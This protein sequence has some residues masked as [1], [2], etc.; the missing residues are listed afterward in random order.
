MK[1]IGLKISLMTLLVA[2]MLPAMAQKSVFRTLTW[3]QAAE[4]A[5][6]EG[7]IVLVD[8]M[9]KPMNEQ[10]KQAMAKT[11]RD[12]FKV[13]EVADFVREKTIAIKIDMGSEAGKAFAPKLVMNMYP[14]YGFFMPNGDILGVVSPYVLAQEPRKLI[15]K[16][17]EVL[18]AAAV[19]RSNSRAIVFEELSLE[20]A[21]KKGEKEGKLVFIDAYTSWCQPCVMM[22]KNIFTLDRVADFYN[23]H[24]I[25]VK[26]DFGQEKA[27]AER[28]K[29]SGYPSFIFVNGKGKAVYVAGGYTEAE[30]FIGYGQTALEK[31]KGIVF[32]TGTWAQALEKA[33][34]EHKYIFMDC[35]TS[36][37]GPCKMLAKN[38]FTDPDAAEFFNTHFV[39]VKYDMEKGEGKMLK[40]KF[41]VK[42]FP[43]L[44]F[45]DGEGELVHCTVGAP[46]LAGLLAEGQAVLDGKGL[47]ALTKAYE[48]GNREPD[49]ITS[50]LEALGNAYKEA[51]AEKVCLDY[52]ATLDKAKLHEKAYWDLFVKYIKDV[53]SDV[54]AYVYENRE[55]LCQSIGEKEVKGKIRTVWMI[56]ANR[57][58]TGQGEEAVLDEKGFKRYCKRLMKADVAGKA[59]IIEDA[60]M[61][62]AEKLGDWKTYIDLG[63]AKLKAGKVG[64][65]ILYNWGLRVNRMCKDT[66]LRKR[67][68]A[69][70]EQAVEDCKKRETEGGKEGMMSFRPYFERLASDLQQPAVEK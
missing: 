69:W 4:L 31:A 39:N 29:V 62:N 25:N 9:R 21:V 43:T 1:K 35:Y 12:I 6:K 38:V 33:K 45:I 68:A 7:K 46:D 41:G 67:A 28:F 19:K 11:E 66:A 10:A 34:A 26:L 17:E 61:N 2:F 23:E 52:F 63:D 70:F 50:Y 56:G 36:W 16:G 53:D 40:E 22:A 49:F 5:E 24:F 8:A 44:N 65:L 18:K 58:V 51:E 54:F 30:E 59:E 57:F 37:C 42:A 48:A 20:E 13:K 3:E 27:L 64:D 15:E 60:K 32:E 14:T 47:V 55:A